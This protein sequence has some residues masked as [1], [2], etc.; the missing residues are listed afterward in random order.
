MTTVT[1]RVNQRTKV[2]D[3]NSCLLGERSESDFPCRERQRKEENLYSLG[4]CK[5]SL[6]VFEIKEPFKDTN[7]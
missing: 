4:H 3:I 1:E 7:L 6:L 5:V 2:V